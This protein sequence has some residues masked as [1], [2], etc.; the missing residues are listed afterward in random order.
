MPQS[1]IDAYR[2]LVPPWTQNQALV[3]RYVAGHW[4]PG[5]PRP[6]EAAFPVTQQPT[7]APRAVAVYVPAARPTQAVAAR[8][9][10]GQGG[11][12]PVCHEPM[13]DAF[14]RTRPTNG[15]WVHVR[16]RAAEEQNV[17]RLRQ[18][19]ERA[20]IWLPLS[21]KD[22]AVGALK[23]P[24][25]PRMV[26]MRGEAYDQNQIIRLLSRA[27]ESGF[28]LVLLLLKRM[29]ER[30]TP[31]ELRDRQTKDANF[32]GFN[33]PDASLAMDMLDYYDR[34]GYSKFLHTRM[35]KLLLKYVNTQLPEI[36]NLGAKENG[37][38]VRTNPV[39]RRNW[40]EKPLFYNDAYWG[41]WSRI[42]S[43]H[44]GTT[45]ELNLTPINPR[46]PGAWEEQVAGF[47]IRRH[48]TPRD[49]SRVAN[50]LP[51]RVKESM[52]GRLDAD[53]VLALLNTPDREILEQI[54]WDKYERVCNGGANLANIKKS[55]TELLA[56]VHKNSRPSFIRAPSLRAEERVRNRAGKFGT[57][58]SDA[59]DD[60]AYILW[61]GA[62]SPVFESLR[63]QIDVVAPSEEKAHKNVR[64]NPAEMQLFRL[65]NQGIDQDENERFVAAESEAAAIAIIE[66]RTGLENGGEV[67]WLYVE[68]LGPTTGS[69]RVVRATP[70]P[71]HG[72]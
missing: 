42:L 65:Y 30:Q 8:A 9:P 22:T 20:H 3:D 16:C 31:A 40:I 4:P 46:D 25:L 71:V 1:R 29:A 11:G 48:Q 66:A 64:R 39:A 69:P 49:H 32:V 15:R 57:V 35:S 14:D 56:R 45:V 43:W 52:L 23:A 54:D 68:S 67:M 62:A 13:K 72:I 50:R 41:T 37:Y 61:D 2:A 58:L 21:L 19:A 27:D 33:Q 18:E 10:R 7:P 38:A 44:A 17:E 12:C 59:A 70:P 36:M 6:S 55:P 26:Q 53:L 24:Q 51:E 5:D 63:A 47:R 34:E 60:H 28:K